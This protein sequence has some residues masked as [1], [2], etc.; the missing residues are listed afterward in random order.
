[1]SETYQSKQERRQRL[2]ESLPEG[3]RPHVS[4]RNIEAVAALS[5]QVQTRLLEAVQAGLKRDV[6]KRQPFVEWMVGIG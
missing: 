5:T 2:L 1:M 3:L 6:Y 4:I